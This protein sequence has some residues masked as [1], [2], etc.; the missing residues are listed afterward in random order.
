MPNTVTD[1]ID[2]ID[3]LDGKQ[4]VGDVMSE[5]EHRGTA[6]FLIVPPMLEL[7]PAGAIPGLPSIIAAIT[8]LFAAQIA[9][10]RPHL[11]VPHF[12]AK[13][14]VPD[15]KLG[16]T[17]EFLRP[18]ASWLDKRL[19]GQ[20]LQFLVGDPARRMAAALVIALCVAVPPLEVV[21]GASSLPM[22]A[23]LCVGLALLF[24]NGILMLLGC[25]ASVAAIY[26]VTRLL[27]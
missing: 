3:Q 25:G 9:V 19:T 20:H 22:I 16:Q 10:G 23:I 4:T 12:L 21:P 7:S 24:R 11:W 2:G 17:L 27:T 8:A 18:L 26:V 6:P 1:I 5:L 14:P 13:R 15:G